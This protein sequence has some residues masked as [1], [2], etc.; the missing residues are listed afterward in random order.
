MVGIDHTA[1]NVRENYTTKS[2]LQHHPCLLVKRL[3]YR[4]LK[5]ERFLLAVKPCLGSFDGQFFWSTHWDGVS[6]VN[7]GSP[8][9]GKLLPASKIQQPGESPIY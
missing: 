7:A 6:M 1:P 5:S 3:Q 8:Y 9:L 2:R 4:V